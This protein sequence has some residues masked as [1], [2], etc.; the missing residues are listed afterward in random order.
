M[1]LDHRLELVDDDDDIELKTVECI[2]VGYDVGVY[3]YRA[4][5]RGR[6]VLACCVGAPTYHNKTMPPQTTS[7]H[8]FIK[9]RHL[10]INPMPC[11]AGHSSTA[12]LVHVVGALWGP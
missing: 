7:R 1:Q 8:Q 9:K 11:G 4:W 3:T 2:D 12:Q 6:I 10:G 5:V